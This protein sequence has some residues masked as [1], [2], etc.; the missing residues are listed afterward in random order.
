MNFS[1]LHSLP[2]TSNIDPTTRQSSLG[3][4]ENFIKN[5]LRP[6][7]CCLICCDTFSENHQPVLLPC[8]HIFGYPCIKK[9]LRNGRG[10]NTACPH[11]RHVFFERRNKS[12]FDAVTVWTRLSEE[13]PERLHAL[14]SHML[15][16]IQGLWKQHTNGIF[17]VTE[18][19][20]NAIIPALMETARTASTQLSTNTDP[21]LDCYNLVA[22][23]WDSL[24]RPD[25][26]TGLAIPLVRLAR[27][28]SCASC[29]LP[30]WLTT[31]MRTNRLLWTANACIDIERTD[32]SWNYILDAATGSGKE[33]EKYFPLLH[34]YTVL[35]SQYIVNNPQPLCLPIRRHEI[36]NLVVEC[37]C[38]RIVGETWKGKPSNE[39]KDMLVTV[40][41]ELRRYQLDKKKPSLRGHSDEN[42]I[43][44]GI[45]ALAR[46]N[47]RKERKL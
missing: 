21:V 12:S 7:D 10:N 38:K 32:V 24:G 5:S 26:A 4:M 15:V 9:W 39:L 42:D 3:S 33:S 31:V 25:V 37:C 46:W 47:A 34:L 8:D 13:Q 2:F 23:S 28:T 16:G 20:D 17:T 27:L 45:W 29:T 6:V 1:N 18:V 43:V 11:C 36:M 22:A 44:R 41:E 30:K 35:I 19:L 14:M 40:F